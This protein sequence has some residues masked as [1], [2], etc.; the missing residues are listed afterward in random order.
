MKFEKI[1]ENKLKIVLSNNELP[2]SS[3]LDEFMTDSDSAKNSFIH[4]L[5][6]AKDAVGFNSKDYKIKI[7]AKAMANGDYVFIITKLVK[8]RRGNI[9]VTPRKVIKKYNSNSIYSIYQFNSFD[10]FC[11]CCSYLKTHK[12]NYL[13]N[14]CKSCVLYEYG[15]YY[16]LSLKYINHNYKKLP[17]FYSTITEFSKY[18]SSKPMFIA[19]L[20]EHGRIFI[21]N[22]ALLTCQKYFN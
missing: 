20:K 18:F 2:H 9:V 21:N 7:D 17:M 8:L 19:T 15:N 10:D 6:E 1:N 3:T 4:L 13:N 11:D 14:L 16:Y 22:N 5:D 12:I